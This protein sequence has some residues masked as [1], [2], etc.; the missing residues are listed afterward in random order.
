MQQH[1]EEISAQVRPGAH[2]LLI[3]DRTGWHTTKKRDISANIT[4]L[5]LPPRSHELNPTENT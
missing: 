1:L 5:P 2:A 3:L 4:L